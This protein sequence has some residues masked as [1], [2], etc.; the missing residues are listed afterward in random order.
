MREYNN[1]VVIDCSFGDH[2][3]NYEPMLLKNKNLRKKKTKIQD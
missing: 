1:I 3:I 2:N